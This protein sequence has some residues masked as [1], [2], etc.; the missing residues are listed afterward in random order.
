M[1]RLF[2]W[3]RLYD[4]SKKPSNDAHERKTVLMHGLS[5]CV[6]SKILTQTASEDSYWRKAIQMSGVFI[7]C[8]SSRISHSSPDNSLRGEAVTYF[9]LQQLKHQI[10]KIIWRLILLKNHSNV[11][12]VPMQQDRKDTSN[13]TWRPITKIIDLKLLC[14]HT[15]QLTNLIN[16]NFRNY[17]LVSGLW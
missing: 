2:I 4:K 16:M 11:N 3:I 5:I 10:L 14:V 7:L 13:S 1:H 8:R 15:N 9:H 12:C 17:I 6:Y